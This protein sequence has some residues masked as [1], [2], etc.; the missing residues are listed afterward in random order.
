MKVKVIILVNRQA[1]IQ[2]K[3]MIEKTL[4]YKDGKNLMKKN[5]MLLVLTLKI[6]VLIWKKRV[7][8]LFKN[9]MLT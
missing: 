1:F 6:I 3:Y 5:M 2:R 9:K 8:H 7:K 4:F